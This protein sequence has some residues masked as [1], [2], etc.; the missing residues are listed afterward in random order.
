MKRM[1]LRLIGALL[2]LIMCLSVLPTEV[3]AWK[4]MTHVN[5]A[6]LILLEL[7]RSAAHNNWGFASVDVYAPYDS[8]IRYTYTI[9]LEFQLAL[10]MYPDAFRAG[11]M[12][13]DFYPDMLTGQGYIHP[14]FI[15]PKDANKT[16]GSGE[17][18]TLLCDSVNSLPQGSGERMEA[19]A[20]T[21]G[22]MLHFC[23][24]MFGHDFINSFAGG[25]YPSLTDVRY[26]NSKD[27]NLNII[28]S[29]M[30]EESYMDSLVN[31]QF[32]HD[33]DYLDI[34]APVRFVADTMVFNGHANNGAAE[35][36]GK[37]GSVPAQY[38]YLVNLRTKL[39]KKAEQWRPSTEA[40]T[41]ATV[42]YLDAWIKDLDEATYALVKS[43]DRMAN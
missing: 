28:L 18:I 16:I 24:D 37:Y 19:L 42:K 10:S 17:W 32:Y 22:F 8:G 2:V 13:P 25:T 27:P 38:S 40:F 7:R 33:S 6:D 26:T 5:S 15:D 20:F 34:A 4:N 43:F 36:F 3:F 35:I 31:W 41:A 11:S 12:G 21:L 23:G 39:Y 29:H 1:G 9:P 14:F 30:S